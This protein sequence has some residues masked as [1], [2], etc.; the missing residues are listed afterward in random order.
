MQTLGARR[1]MYA[2]EQYGW[3]GVA[4]TIQALRKAAIS[5]APVR[6]EGPIERV[7]EVAMHHAPH[8]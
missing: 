4:V 3:C 6:T 5:D 1:A 2:A 8:H 7:D